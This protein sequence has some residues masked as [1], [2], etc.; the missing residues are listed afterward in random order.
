MNRNRLVSRTFRVPQ[1]SLKR[2]DAE[3]KNRDV[4]VNALLNQMLTK[5]LTFDLFGEKANPV[6][7]AEATLLAMMD[8][9]TPE[10]MEQA[11]TIAG[12]KVLSSLFAHYNIKPTLDSVL[13]YHIRPM[14][15][16]S[17]WYSA[18]YHEEEQKIALHHTFGLKWSYFL[19]GHVGASIRSVLK[20]EPKIEISESSVVIYLR[21]QTIK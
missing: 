21:N 2:L 5:Y 1:E 10:Q 14:S 9:L 16:Y 7:I 20:I 13:E 12:S 15:K 4:S 19:K 6:V 8:R 17:R 3:A 11:G 18:K